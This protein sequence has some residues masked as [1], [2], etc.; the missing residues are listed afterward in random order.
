MGIAVRAGTGPPVTPAPHRQVDPPDRSFAGF[1]VRHDGLLQDRAALVGHAYGA[2]PY[3]VFWS[4]RAE[5]WEQWPGQANE[6]DRIGA[7][8][9]CLRRAGVRRGTDRPLPDPAIGP[10]PGPAVVAAVRDLAPV[11][12]RPDPW[13]LLEP[14]VMRPLRALVHLDAISR[15]IAVLAWLGVPADVAAREVG[16]GVDHPD[17]HDRAM[18]FW[19]H[20]IRG[21]GA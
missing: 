11:W 8:A 1:V 7:L 3:E 4:T 19:R 14:A 13:T 6:A 12:R 18:R 10:D 20:V 15:D 21:A 17:A 9:L 16:L 2:A 5:L